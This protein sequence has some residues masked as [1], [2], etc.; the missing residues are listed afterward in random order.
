MSLAGSGAQAHNRP[1]IDETHGRTDAPMPRLDSEFR[2]QLVGIT[3]RPVAHSFFSTA[4][5]FSLARIA[6]C[7]R[8]NDSALLGG[9]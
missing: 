6:N 2:I 7:S 8:G 9:I 1:S 3:S 4:A 5:L